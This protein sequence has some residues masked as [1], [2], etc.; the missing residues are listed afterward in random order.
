MVVGGMVAWE[1]NQKRER[2][3]AENYMK[4][5]KGLKN[6]SFWVINSKNFHWGGSDLLCRRKLIRR[7][8]K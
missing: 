2:K 3:W 5:G 6:A 4:K 7:G 1:K 8:K